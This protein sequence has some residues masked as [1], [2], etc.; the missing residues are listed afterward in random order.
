LVG[1]I[2]DA[3]LFEPSRRYRW[4]GLPAARRALLVSAH[5]GSLV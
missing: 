1:R 4:E 2:D 5:W 3:L